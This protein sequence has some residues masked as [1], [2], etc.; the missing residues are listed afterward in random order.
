[1]ADQPA[2]TPNPFMQTGAGTPPG[3]TSLN[4]LVGNQGE[5]IKAAQTLLDLLE[6]QPEAI[7]KAIGYTKDWQ[8]QLKS[9]VKYTEDYEDSFKRLLSMSKQYGESGIFRAKNYNDLLNNLKDLKEAQNQLMRDGFFDKTQQRDLKTQMAFLNTAIQKVGDNLEKTGRKMDEAIDPDLLAELSAKARKAALDVEKMGKAWNNV[10]LRPLTSNLARMNDVLGGSSEI[11]NKITQRATKYATIAGKLE[12]IKLEKQT[13]GKLG[14]QETLAGLNKGQLLRARQAG[15]TGPPSRRI[16]PEKMAQ[17]RKDLAATVSERAGGGGF[18]DRFL[19][20]RAMK[21]VADSAARTATGEA[22]RPGFLARAYEA[23]GGSVTRGLGAAVTGGTAGFMANQAAG[24]ANMSP[25]FMIGELLMKFIDANAKANAEIADKLGEAGIF[26][27]GASGAKDLLMVRKALTPENLGFNY[28]GESYQKNLKIAQAISEGGVNLPELATGVRPTETSGLGMVKNIAYHGAK[29]AGYLDE[30]A[31]AKEIMQ[32]LQEYHTSFIG[33]QDFFEHINRDTA[34]AGITTTK[35]INIIEEINKQF[36]RFGQSLDQTVNTM[37]MLGRTG[38]QSSAD[39]REA[40]AAITNAGQKRT[41]EMQAFLGVQTAMTKGAPE[42]QVR[43][44]EAN[45]SVARKRAQE[46]LGIP[47]LGINAT[48]VTSLEDVRQLQAHLARTPGGTNIERQAANDALNQLGMEIQRLQGYQNFQQKAREGKF[49]EAGLGLA[50]Q[51]AMLGYNLT[52]STM[53]QFRAV[54][55]ALSKANR[56]KGY[57]LEQVLGGAGAE[58]PALVKIM[59]ALQTDPS[60]LQKLMRV[61]QVQAQ[62][63]MQGAREGT[64]SDETYDRLVKIAQKDQ[65]LA[66]KLKRGLGAKAQIQGLSPDDQDMLTALLGK[67]ESVLKDIMETETGA[68]KMAED[69]ITEEERERQK[70]KAED[71]AT[72]TRPLAQIFADAFESLFNTISQPLADIYDWLGQRFGTGASPQEIARVREAWGGGGENT[73]GGLYMKQ[74]LDHFDELKDQNKKDLG[75]VN[76]LLESQPNLEKT[77]KQKFDDL[78]MQKRT[79]ETQGKQ[80]NAA[81]TDLI[82]EQRIITGPRGAKNIQE[83]AAADSIKESA[84]QL[85]PV[86]QKNLDK[87][88]DRLLDKSLSDQQYEALK[89]KGL[90][91]AS[92]IKM[93]TALPVTTRQLPSSITNIQQVTL[94]AVKVA[95]PHQQAPNQSNEGTPATSKTG[96][97][98]TGGQ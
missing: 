79:L 19:T 66:P 84:E 65:T 78:L 85:A 55:V 22:P 11:L 37:R 33:V 64:V 43:Y 91:A 98:P 76:H 14:M 72:N 75:E 86:F 70:Q 31:A 48:N 57:T 77:D 17:I 97:K 89:A 95:A 74:L 25:Y 62:A 20:Q 26:G 51:N 88:S 50:A 94:E 12:R 87:I 5:Q 6:Q 58:D 59:E 18:I 9:I 92:I 54:Q 34:R 30:G 53:E 15:L 69:Q 4:E 56:G 2:N 40:M 39:V 82:R 44:Q 81:Q 96:T 29:L 52:G 73:P 41:F 61:G 83:I 46:A 35:Y 8:T 13:A 90:D 71:V 80:I 42:E 47:S 24:L 7:K 63:T 32:V 27:G 49:G 21:Q 67:N 68:N 23:G 45:V 16:A 28:T 36:D 93:T 38:I 10:H 60:M 1:M 3:Q